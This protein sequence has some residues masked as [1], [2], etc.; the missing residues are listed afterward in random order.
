M[1]AHEM[2]S[3]QGKLS[4]AALKVTSLSIIKINR[5]RLHLRDLVLAVTN[6]VH[7]LIL[8]RLM[9]INSLL[10]SLEMLKHEVFENTKA[11]VGIALEDLKDEE[12][13]QNI[14]L[15]NLT[16][17]LPQQL[18]IARVVRVSLITEVCQSLDPHVTIDRL[19]LEDKGVALADLEHI[20]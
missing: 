14:L 11:Q 13:R 12:G 2:D 6:L 16:Q 4:I 8:T 15:A 19:F 5:S 20:G 10:L 3:R 18:I 7:F 1:L 9:L 17:G